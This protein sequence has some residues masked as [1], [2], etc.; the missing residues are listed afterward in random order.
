MSE[1][2]KVMFAEISKDYD[3]MNTVLSFGIHHLWRKKVVKLANVNENSK[4]LD[5][6]SGTG[7]LAIEF[8]KTAKKG[9]VFA[10]DF[11][12]EML[13]YIKPKE[14]KLNIK[15]KTEFADVMNLKYE[16]N[17]FDV[18]SI[19]FGIRNVDNP[20]QGVSEMARVVKAGGKVIIL[21]TGQPKGL[22]KPI[23]K[24]Y[25]Q[26]IMPFLGSIVA[27]NE[28]AYTYLPQTASKFPYGDMFVEIM[29]STEKFSEIKAYPVTFGVAYIYVGIVK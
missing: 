11:C 3:K 1:A 18:S 20:K 23:Y 28:A 15:V 5:C 22:L 21:E 26:K 2:I 8:K 17:Y 24:L 29:N 4:V 7:D 13:D 9:E 6:A 19:S 10:T 14:E 16:D 25:S 27:K 12:V